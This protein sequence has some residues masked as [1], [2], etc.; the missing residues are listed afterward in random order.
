MD[1]D[2]QNDSSPT[3]K[4]EKLSF[5]ILAAAILAGVLGLALIVLII[6]VGVL[7]VSGKSFETQSLK[8]YGLYEGH[9][10]AEGALFAHSNLLIFPKTLPANA[11]VNDFFYA[12]SS[13]GL[14][15]SYQL[16]LD[17]QL[18][19][20]EFQEEI[21]RLH[22]LSVSYGEKTNRVIYDAE[23]FLYPAYVTIC[24]ADGDLEFALIDAENHRVVAVLA[25]KGRGSLDNSL[26][27]ANLPKYD[28]GTN[29]FGYSLYQ[30]EVSDGVMM[31]GQEAANPSP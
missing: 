16:L 29:W 6:C 18:P 30:F 21:D 22:N 26:F 17:Y 14:D 11:K 27:P 15:N 20:D 10:E 13:K 23:N 24:T 2:W 5:G 1:S 9:V 7:L 28:V 19:P 25:L 3:A 4:K 31:T 8:D 12:C